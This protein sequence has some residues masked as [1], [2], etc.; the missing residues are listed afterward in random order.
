MKVL[1]TEC[2]NWSEEIAAGVILQDQMHESRESS[3]NLW[4]VQISV[5]M[6]GVTSDD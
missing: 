6:P 5:I 3:A 4:M 2:H 1:E